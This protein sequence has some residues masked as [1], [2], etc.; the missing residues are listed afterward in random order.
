M[1]CTE[2][3]CSFQTTLALVYMYN[4]QM[5]TMN[6][7]DFSYLVFC[8]VRKM[9]P[10]STCIVLTCIVLN[11][12]V[13]FRLYYSSQLILSIFHFLALQAMCS[14]PN[15]CSPISLLLQKQDK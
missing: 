15:S 1:Y 6:N 12:F 5:I 4:C 2:P 9:Y 10:G 11:H 3:L 8:V 7:S 13:L 14:A